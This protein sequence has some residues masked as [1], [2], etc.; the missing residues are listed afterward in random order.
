MPSLVGELKNRTFEGTYPKSP[1]FW[2][3]SSEVGTLSIKTATKDL[4]L[5]RD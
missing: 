4:S 3:S 5:G 2:T 1:V